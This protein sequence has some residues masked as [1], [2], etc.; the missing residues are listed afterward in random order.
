[1]PEIIAD[2]RV[3][4]RSIHHATYNTKYVD[5]VIW[6]C[7]MGLILVAKLLFE[8]AEYATDIM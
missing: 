1:M 8:K 7:A 2:Q 5:I 3:V 6:W 4:L